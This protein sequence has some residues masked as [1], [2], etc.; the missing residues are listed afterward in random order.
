MFLLENKTKSKLY[1]IEFSISITHM[2]FAKFLPTLYFHH[3]DSGNC[4]DKWDLGGP[5]DS[6]RQCENAPLQNTFRQP[7]GQNLLSLQ[8]VIKKEGHI[9]LLCG[10]N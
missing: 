7:H 1:F 9:C 2:P 8:I 3:A 5:L 4:V 6:S 10:W